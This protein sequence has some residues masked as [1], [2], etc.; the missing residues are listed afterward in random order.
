ML[1]NRI[2]GIIGPKGSGKSYRAARMFKL[3]KRA[4]LYDIARDVGYYQNATY[5]VNDT[6]QLFKIIR[7]EEEFRIVYQVQDGDLL[8]KG[9]ELIYTT[10]T[11]IAEECFY[12]GNITLF[13]DEAH[14]LCTQ[15]SIDWRLRKVIRLSRHQQL[16]VVWISQSMNEIH[17]EIRRN[18]D[19]YHF[20]K[21]HEPRDLEAIVDR[22]GE[23]TSAKVANLKRLKRENGRVVPGECFVWVSDEQ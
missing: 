9:K 1:Q 22:C 19:E 14:E 2:I 4:V 18:T 7:K 6:T 8:P 5:I 13:L 12:T 21:I 23:Y 10:A 16:N 17:R 15:W 11:P 20:Y 3:C